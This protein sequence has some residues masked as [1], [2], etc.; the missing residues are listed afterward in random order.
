ML[1]SERESIVDIANR[2]EGVHRDARGT[3]RRAEKTSRPGRAAW[4][5]QSTPAGKWTDADDIKGDGRQAVAPSAHAGG[6]L[7]GDIL[8]ARDGRAAPIHGEVT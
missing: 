6:F 3:T 7:G 1:T 8:A 2:I 4:R 5:R